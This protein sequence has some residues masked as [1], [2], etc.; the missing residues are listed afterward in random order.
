[1]NELSVS[2]ST[3]VSDL[4]LLEKRGIVNKV[5]LGREN[6]YLNEKLFDFL[7]NAFHVDM[8]KIDS[9]DSNG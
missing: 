6:F 3:A 7:L 2:R 1:M 4:Y 8:N 5:K 9:I